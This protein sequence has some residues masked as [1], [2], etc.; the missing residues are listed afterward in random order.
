MPPV[1]IGAVALGGAAVAAGGLT[2]AFAAGGLIGFAANFGASMLLSG[3]AQSLMPSPTVGSMALQS[4]SVT[5]REPVMPRD[6]VYGRVRKGGVL[7]FLHSTGDAD[8]DL[9]L[10][11][12]L[13][14]HRVK[15]IGAIYFEGEMAFDATG[16]PIGRWANTA[17]LEKRLGSETQTAFEGLRAAAPEHW[18]AAH[19]LRGCAAIYLRLTYDADVYPWRLQIEA[20][21]PL[22]EARARYFAQLRRKRTDP[23]VLTELSTEEGGITWINDT[24]L[25]LSLSVEQT[26]QLSPGQVVMDLIRRDLTP[27]VHLGILLEVPVL[28]PVTRGGGV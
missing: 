13:A 15:S 23:E 19:Q 25:E 28:W 4:R 11:I 7:V 24:V 2:A 17:H 21:V 16:A 8:K 14:A 12:V 20:E 6:M 9:H 27:V 22:F 10:V 26:A 18:T 3:A 5:V 1:V